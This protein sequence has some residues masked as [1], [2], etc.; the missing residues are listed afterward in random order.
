L[1]PPSSRWRHRRSAAAD[2]G[3]CEATGAEQQFQVAQLPPVQNDGPVV[4]DADIATHAI[5]ADPE[6]TNFIVRLDLTEHGMP[7]K[8]EQMWTRTDDHR[9]FELCCIPFFL[10]GQSLGD[11]LV[12]DTKT[13]AHAVH[14]K[15]GHHTIRIVFLDDEAAHTRH[16]ALHKS[17]VSDHGCQVEFRAGNHYA[18]IDIPPGTDEHAVLA[19]LA[20]LAESGVLT[21]EWADPAASAE[22][23]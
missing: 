1:L 13:G 20:P 2:F 11:I 9:L 16:A 8:Y 18:A 4:N 7:G 6:R 3:A 12:I 10:Y 22:Q 14:A 23:D 21:W 5:P 19:T 17:L 15:S